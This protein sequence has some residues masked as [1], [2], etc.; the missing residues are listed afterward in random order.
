MGRHL[1]IACL[2]TFVLGGCEWMAA[3]SCSAATTEPCDPEAFEARCLDDHSL[4]NCTQLQR[5]GDNHVGS[6]WHVFRDSCFHGDVCRLI[7][8]FAECVAPPEESCDLDTDERRCVDGRVQYCAPLD[9]YRGERYWDGTSARWG[10]LDEVCHP[11]SAL[12]P[13]SG[14]ADETEQL[15]APR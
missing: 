2:W 12:V 5:A 14:A 8:G 7:D 13:A 11:S 1:A 10:H 3:L 15:E 9:T 4:V 6:G